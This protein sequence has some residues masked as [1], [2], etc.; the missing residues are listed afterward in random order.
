[1]VGREGDIQK[2]LAPCLKGMGPKLNFGIKTFQG[3]LSKH[4]YF[5]VFF[6]SKANL[7]ASLLQY[8]QLS[9]KCAKVC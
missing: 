5:L 4:F 3:E 8:Q 7:N 9:G 1:M 2:G 6:H